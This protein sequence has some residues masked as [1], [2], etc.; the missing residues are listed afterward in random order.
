MAKVQ[1]DSELKEIL[2]TFLK[3]RENDCHQLKEL[4]EAGNLAGVKKI[5]HK[6]SGSSGGYGFKELGEIAKNI[7]LAAESGDQEKAS[8]LIESF[9]N[10]VQTI[11]VEYI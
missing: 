7:E 8:K 1:V 4:I 10:Y 3:N 2:P 9:V 11:E 6:V 5:G